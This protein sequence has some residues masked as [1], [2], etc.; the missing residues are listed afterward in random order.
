MEGG[1]RY[2]ESG[3]LWQ[4][5]SFAGSPDCGAAARTIWRSD[6]DNAHSVFG[7]GLA[8]LARL[9]GAAAHGHDL[10]AGRASEQRKSVK[11]LSILGSPITFLL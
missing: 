10:P 4:L 2:L 8:L 9:R 5:L 11:C 7:Y 1:K 6:L 3:A